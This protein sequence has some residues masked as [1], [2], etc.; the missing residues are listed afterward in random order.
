MDFI[1]NRDRTQDMP[2]SK[3]VILQV[4]SIFTCAYISTLVCYV[5]DV[6]FYII[7]E[8]EE[9]SKYERIYSKLE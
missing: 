2:E 3:V 8:S 4:K 9:K 6:L 7:K 5:L 1:Q